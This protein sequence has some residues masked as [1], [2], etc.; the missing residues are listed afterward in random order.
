M[1]RFIFGILACL[2]LMTATPVM[3]SASSSTLINIAHSYMGS[4]YVYGGTSAAGFDCSGFTQRVFSDSGSS[5]PRTTS[6][7]FN[8]GAPVDKGNLQPGDLVFF[9][10]NG[11]SVSHVGIYIGSSNFVH[12]SSSRGVMISS[13]HDPHYWGSRY[14]GARRPNA[15]PAVKP[16]AEEVAEEKVEKKQE[17]PKVEA[18]KEVKKTSQPVVT[19]KAVATLSKPKAVAQPVVTPPVQKTKT[20]E[21]KAEDVEEEAEVESEEL[22]AQIEYSP[23]HPTALSLKYSQLVHVRGLDYVLLEKII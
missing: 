23:I 8:V 1:K 2:L 4:P 11:K 20:E 9:N 21:V 17:Q 12:A 16:K 7:Q 22:L 13:I 10:T 15:Q 19:Q 6:G 5:L 18:K 3:A 14:I